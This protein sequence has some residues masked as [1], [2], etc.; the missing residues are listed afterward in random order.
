LFRRG[1]K[2]K[3]KKKKKNLGLSSITQCTGKR[4]PTSPQKGQGNAGKVPGFKKGTARLEFSLLGGAGGWGKESMNKE[5]GGV[6]GEYSFS[7]G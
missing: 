3:H 4:G 1:G 5:R 2:N 6:K 7:G